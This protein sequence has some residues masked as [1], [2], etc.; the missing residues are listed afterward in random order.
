MAPT[1]TAKLS[2]AK[3][4]AIDD[5]KAQLTIS[6]EQL[7]TITQQFLNE[8]ALGLTAYN[9]PMAMIR[10]HAYIPLST[11]LTQSSELCD[12]SP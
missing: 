12:G 11:P 9:H 2:A 10:E 3:Q 8:F 1:T 5:V 6:H 4:K 7:H